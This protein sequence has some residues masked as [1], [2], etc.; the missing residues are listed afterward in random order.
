MK[1]KE[2]ELRGARILGAPLDPPIEMKNFHHLMRP[3]LS[4]SIWIDF[5]LF[6]QRKSIFLTYFSEYGNAQSPRV[7]LPV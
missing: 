3:D 7:Q 1:M 5:S 4:L 2:I 6:G